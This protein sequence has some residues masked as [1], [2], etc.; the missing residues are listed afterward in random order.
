MQFGASSSE[1]RGRSHRACQAVCPAGERSGGTGRNKKRL[2]HGHHPRGGSGRGKYGIHRERR[3]QQGLLDRERV[4]QPD[5]RRP[6]PGGKARDRGKAYERR[7]E[8]SS[9][10]EPSLSYHRFRGERE[11]GYLYDSAQKRR[12]RPVLP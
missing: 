8:K 5:N 6:F 7:G 1:N 4:H 2:E 9:Q 11:G 3:G 12:K 10:V